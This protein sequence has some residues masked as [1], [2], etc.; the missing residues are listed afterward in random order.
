MRRDKTFWDCSPDAELQTYMG[1]F[2]NSSDGLS[3]YC[4]TLYKRLGSDLLTVA[5]VGGLPP[6]IRHPEKIKTLFWM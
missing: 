1:F 2:E 4:Y 3:T 6:Q 5:I